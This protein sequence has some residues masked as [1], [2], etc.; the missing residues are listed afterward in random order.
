ML[1]HATINRINRSQPSPNLQVTQIH[2]S[3]P[4]LNDSRSFDVVDAAPVVHQRS[5]SS[6]L[7]QVIP[8]F[9]SP[10]RRRLDF[11]RAGTPV[12]SPETYLHQSNGQDSPLFSNH[13]SPRST[14]T[15]M[16]FSQNRIQSPQMSPV[17]LDS[18]VK[19]FNNGKVDNNDSL[20]MLSSPS[21]LKSTPTKP[22]H[23][24]SM[25]RI[26]AQSLSQDVE[27][28]TLQVTSQTK[29][30]QIVRTLLRKF[31]LK[32]RDPNLFYLTLE[33]CIRIDGLKSKN[34]M[35]LSDDA[36]P[37][38]LQQCCS[39]PPH[40]DIKFTLQMRAGALVKIYCSDVVQDARYKC[41]SLS[42]QTT[43]EETIELMVHCL[44]LNNASAQTSATNCNGGIDQS[45]L[46]LTGSPGS[47]ASSNSS[48]SGIESDPNNHFMQPISSQQHIAI[49]TMAT[50]NHLDSNSRASSITSISTSSNTSTISSSLI[51]QYCLI[52]ECR[53][54]N[55][56]RILESDEYLVDVY[57]S[58]VSEAKGHSVD[59]SRT[60]SSPPASSGNTSKSSSDDPSQSSPDQWFL[61]KL[62]KRDEYYSRL[63]CPTT[64]I[65]LPN[66]R[67]DPPRVPLMPTVPLSLVNQFNSDTNLKQIVSTTQ[68]EVMNRSRSNCNSS[69]LYNP[70]TDRPATL[71]PQFILLPPVKPRRR[72]ISNVSS[73]F[74]PPMMTQIA[75]GHTRDSRR[76]YD[77]ARL[78]EDL[79]R[80]DVAS[81][82][83]AE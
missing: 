71:P 81:D 56:R 82:Q 30:S 41:L 63:Q 53:D 52:I 46:R 39:N 1:K 45:R 10:A 40:N 51:D 27:Y 77:P 4:G 76:R 44:N 35:L 69:L 49:N 34:I 7:P 14:P 60:P 73:T 47:T 54:T 31:R 22:P 8:G 20:S 38:Q 12:H 5:Y 62:L 23:S 32:H 64:A 72:N 25:I 59:L 15:K 65:K 26:F 19:R 79:S 78:A 29:S 57:Q 3:Q 58:M 36:C 37:L 17:G 43:V 55:Y 67:R 11:N 9:T 13:A 21:S 75:R 24:E 70:L 6:I 61:I 33:R 66:P 48:S 50:S 16:L 2:Q 80:L 18:T 42:T 28:L 83:I 68:I 74:G